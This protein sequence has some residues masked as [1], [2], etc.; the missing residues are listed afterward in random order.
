VETRF[1]LWC[2]PLWA[3]LVVTVLAVYWMG[4]KLAGLR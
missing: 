1:R 4:R 2:H 3:A